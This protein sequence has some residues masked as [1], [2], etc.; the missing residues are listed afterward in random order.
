MKVDLKI[1]ANLLPESSVDVGFGG[2]VALKYQKQ[3]RLQMNI[4]FENVNFFRS[5]S[6]ISSVFQFTWGSS[7]DT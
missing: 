6:N 7:I 4:N 2:I 5:T 1:E 3:P